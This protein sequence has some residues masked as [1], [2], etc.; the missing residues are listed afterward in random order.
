MK[1]ISYD[2]LVMLLDEY[3]VFRSLNNPTAEADNEKFTWEI[4]NSMDEQFATL[5]QRLQQLD[6]L[7][8]EVRCRVLCLC[9][10]AVCLIICV[11][12]FAFVLLLLLLL[13]LLLVAGSSS[14]GE[15][16]MRRM[17]RKRCGAAGL[18]LLLI[19]AP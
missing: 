12:V 19:G 14:K 2:Y 3:F 6:T 8:D 18:I 10:C 15:E 17:R 13:L 11:R 7:L 9:V 4:V 5:N 1:N 16:R